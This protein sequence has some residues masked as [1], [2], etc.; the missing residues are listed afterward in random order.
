M[1]RGEFREKGNLKKK[2][3][4]KKPAGIDLKR[5]GK[6]MFS[7]T[8]KLRIQRFVSHLTPAHCTFPLRRT[9]TRMTTKIRSQDTKSEERK[10]KKGHAL[11]VRQI[12]VTVDQAWN[13]KQSKY[14][15]E[16][17]WEN[18]THLSLPVNHLSK[19]AAENSTDSRKGGGKDR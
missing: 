17:P 12:S 2:R 14:N 11:A 10:E 9:T 19:A 4:T 7:H 8:S 6:K 5:G 13:N 15:V 3:S 18:E 1:G 16:P